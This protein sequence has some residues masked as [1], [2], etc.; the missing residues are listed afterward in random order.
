MAM[1]AQPAVRVA[2]AWLN[3]EEVQSQIK[4]QRGSPGR[5]SLEKSSLYTFAGREDQIDLQV[6]TFAGCIPPN[7]RRPCKE[8]VEEQLYHAKRALREFTSFFGFV[9]QWSLSMRLLEATLRFG[10]GAPW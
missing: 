10:F 3:D 9:E 5:F 8:R 2:R 6:R 4:G 7:T 1:L